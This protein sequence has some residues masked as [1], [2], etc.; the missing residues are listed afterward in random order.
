MGDGAVLLHGEVRVA[1]IE[2][3]VFKDLFGFI[4]SF[5]H[6]A[7]LE[8]H[9]LLYIGPPHP[10][11]N[12]VVF[13]IQGLFNGKNRWQHL[14]VHLDETQGL[15]GNGL[16]GGRHRGHRIAHVADLFRYHGLLVL[17]RREDT[18]LLRQVLT[19]ND[20]MDSVQSFRLVR[21]DAAD[22]RMGIRTSKQL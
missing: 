18:E 1:L 3:G 7:E 6:L 16:T 9:R 22:V 20:S 17:S 21:V 2:K 8:G 4:E 13:L 12:P 11:V 5:T 15:F 19:G 14:I 10:G